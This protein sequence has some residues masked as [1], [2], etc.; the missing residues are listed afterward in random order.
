MLH[1]LKAAS[2]C[3]N[4]SLTFMSMGNVG[5]ISPESAQYR[6]TEDSHISKYHVVAYEKEIRNCSRALV[7]ILTKSLVFNTKTI[8]VSNATVKK[9]EG[10]PA[11]NAE[12]DPLDAS[13][14]PPRH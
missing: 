1:V 10:E 13:E 12:R 14:P 8:R 11:L 9:E 5:G 3:T 4:T 6:D 7:A 2:V